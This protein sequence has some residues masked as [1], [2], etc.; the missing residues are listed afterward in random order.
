MGNSCEKIIFPLKRPGAQIEFSFAGTLM[1][2]TS[3]SWVPS[4]LV[5]GLA[6]KPMG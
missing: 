1:S 4:A 2:Q 3:R 6:T 5:V